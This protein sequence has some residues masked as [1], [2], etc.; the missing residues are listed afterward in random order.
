MYTK[1]QKLELEVSTLTSLKLLNVIQTSTFGP[2][3][4]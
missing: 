3:N 4:R 2:Q 1:V